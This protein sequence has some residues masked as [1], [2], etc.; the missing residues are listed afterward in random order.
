VK[1]RQVV[2]LIALGL[3]VGVPCWGA[4]TVVEAWRSAAPAF[5]EP[6]SISVNP[7]DGSCWMVDSGG[8]IVHLSAAGADLW[9]SASGALSV[10]VNRTDGSCWVAGGRW[11][12]HLSAAGAELW[13][14]DSG[15]FTNAQT[16]SVN[17]TDGSCWVADYLG[18]QTVHLSA[19]GAEL[20]RSASG[21]FASPRSV[22]VNPTDGSC[23]VADSFHD[24]VVHLSATGAELWRSASGVFSGPSSVSVNAADGSCWVADYWGAMHLSADGA[25]LWRSA[26]GAFTIAESVSVNPEDGSCWVADWESGQVVHLSATGAE[27][28]RSDSGVLSGPWSVSVN[29][30]DGS[31]WVVDYHCSQV[32]HLSATGAELW[33]S[34]GGAFICPDSV[35]VNAADGSCWVADSSSK[36]VVHLSAGGA[37]LWRSAR[38]SFPNPYT[39]SVN[40]T[41]GSCWVAGGG[42][43]MRLS[44]AGAELWRSASGA[45]SDP[46]SVSTNAV[47]GSCWVGDRGHGQVVHLSAAGAEVWRSASGAFSWPQS[48]SVNPRDGSCWVADTYNGQVVHLS[49]AGAEVWRSASGVFSTG[50]QVSTS[51][52]DGSCWVADSDGRRVVH[53]SADGAELWRSASGAFPDPYSVSA[54]SLDGSC[55]VG[56]L[57]CNQVVHVSAAGAELWRSASGAFNWPVSVSVNP[58]DGS[59]WVADSRHGQVVHLAVP[60]YGRAPAVLSY[61]DFEAARSPFSAFAAGPGAADVWRTAC[62]GDPRA[63]SGLYAMEAV[64][65]DR[66]A[67]GL[68]L[69][70]PATPT[71]SAEADLRAWVYVEDRSPG[72]SAQFL[73][74]ALSAGGL[75][76]GAIADQLGWE[77]L[78]DGTSRCLLA[79]DTA[80]ETRGVPAGGWHLVH[81]HYAADSQLLTVSLGGTG[82]AEQAA[83]LAA[84]RS[85]AHVVLEAYGTASGA[86]AR[87]LFDDVQVTL[88][89]YPKTSAS[90]RSFALLEGPEQ[91]VGGQESSYTLTYGNGY[92]VLGTAAGSAPLPQSMHVGLRLPAGYALASADPVPISA[93]GADLVWEVPLPQKQ[94]TGQIL[95]R[96]LT[97]TGLPEATTA[98]L[99]TWASLDPAAASSPLPTDANASDAVWGAAQDLLPQQIALEPRPDLWVRKRGPGTASPGDSV[100]YAITVGNAGTGSAESIV[101]KDA[102]PAET[103]GGTRILANLASLAPGETWTG[104]VSGTLAWG[105]PAGT[106]VLN[107]A[108]VPTAPAEAEI[109]NNEALWTTTIQVAR[110]PNEISVSPAGGVDRGQ[111]LTYSLQCENVGTGTA[112]G[113]YAAMALDEKLSLVTLLVAEGGAGTV[114]VDPYSHTLV[115]EVG[116]LGPGETASTSFGV[117]VSSAARRARPLIG[118]ATV[119]FPSVPEETPTN[120]VA[121]TVKGSFPDIVWDHWALLP[122]EQ[123]KEYGVVGGYPDGNYY[124]LVT[125]TRDQ[126]A[127]FIAR[128]MAGGDAHVPDGPGVATF[129]DVAVGTWA[130]KYIEYAVANHI[131]GGYPDGQYHSDIAVDRGQMAAFIARSLCGSDAAVPVPAGAPTFPDVTDTSPA[132][133]CRKHVEYTVSKGVVGGYPDGNYHP[134]VTVSRDQ[135]AVFIARAFELPQ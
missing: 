106:L 4:E 68:R 76:P 44:A 108:F 3:L 59:C 75:D 35:S 91:V 12:A 114:R 29:S 129:P 103:G 38:G 16:V 28:W 60:D 92:P 8:R 105:L 21:A 95:L 124:P 85:L 5:I 127:A 30:T 19:G 132:A 110:D 61:G 98:S 101:V 20:C 48:V 121:N 14:S 102:M 64:V 52:A 37:D 46:Y 1:I 118:Q 10:S 135:M 71:A 94:Q 77:M 93:N 107:R 31:C 39:V 125:V 78:S 55:W 84:D 18:N 51:L 90:D 122:I 27:L 42:G 113:V 128:T 109:A 36:Q 126:M 82:V 57:D 120:V 123:A 79:G 6:V 45:F 96:A 17:A 88:T 112:H 86:H 74:F 133:W 83:P 72:D 81:V 63:H 50:F 32:V 11:V 87:V 9:R 54:N 34:A 40:A 22:S 89:G 67:T 100:T 62:T 49:A 117:A 116:T 66:S 130:Y 69:D 15:A 80:T 58:A 131:V 7:T 99:W 26:S 33:R 24:Q 41:D 25:E 115:W 70:L 43:V 134:E 53:L 56:D 111:R 23:W 97:P 2:S 65:R 104:A 13:R 73:G 47:D 119:Y